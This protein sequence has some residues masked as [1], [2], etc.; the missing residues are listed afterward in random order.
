M[1]GKALVACLLL[2]GCVRVVTER[3]AVRLSDR[4]RELGGTPVVER[5][6]YGQ[7]MGEISDVRCNGLNEHPKEGR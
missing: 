7:R 6:E 2:T 1:K 4:C 3:E 5:I